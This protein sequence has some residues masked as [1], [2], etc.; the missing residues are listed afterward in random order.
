MNDSMTTDF[1]KGPIFR[2]LVKFALPFV[3]A[4]LLQALY[5]IV[6]MV[7]VGRFVGSVG[8]SAVSVGGNV[9]MLLTCLAM[10]FST[11]AQILISQLVGRGDKDGVSR[12]I[13]TIFT[14]M[15]ILGVAV[16]VV[17]LALVNCFADWLNT[18]AEAYDQA[19][20]YMYICIGGMIFTVG[21][22]AVSAVLR[23]MGDSKRPLLFITIASVTNLV[24]DLLFVVWLGMS[25]A[26]AAL[27]TIIGQAVSFIFS[28]VYLYRR[29]TA[30][31]FDF[32]RASF[33]ID[34]ALLK[35]F[36]KLG[37]PM[38]LQWGAVSVSYTVISAAVNTYG[39]A[40]S[41]IS[42]AGGKLTSILGVFAGSIQTAASGMVGQNIS[43]GELE[44]TKKITLCAEAICITCGVVVCALVLIFP[45]PLISIFTSDEDVLALSRMYMNAT[46]AGYFASFL[47]SPTNGLIQGVGA[48]T[49]NFVV[50]LIDSVI[51]RI[52]LSL[53]LGGVLGFGLSGFWWGGSLA[54]YVTVVAG[55]WFLFSGRW[56]KYKLL[57]Q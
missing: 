24:L 57:D 45:R 16:T 33:R 41:A 26:G 31:G 39:L 55:F 42:G 18:P 7:I 38:T 52:G 49:F 32:R 51:A 27:A 21:Y 29:R 48:M 34:T 17:G 37:L 15:L 28:I 10:G 25:A 22:N 44:R 40:A 11:G 54:G 50:A 43:A 46:A 1:T 53:L 35:I 12:C 5:N 36:V 20:Y 4:N 9:T 3:L 56:K 30:F 13:G 14:S 2:Q 23:G 6:D 19:R 8:L 47:M